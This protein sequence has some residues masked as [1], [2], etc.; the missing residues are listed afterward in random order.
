M[1]NSYMKLVRIPKDDEINT[2]L[3]PL[4]HSTMMHLFGKPGKLTKNCSPLTNPKLIAQ[5]VTRKFNNFTVTGWEP[6]VEDLHAILLDVYHFDKELHALIGSAGM[7]CCRMVR[8]ADGSPST[9]YSNHSWYCAFDMTFGGILVPQNA[10]MI[11][12]GMLDVYSIMHKHKWYW[13]AEFSTADP[14][15]SEPSLERLLELWAK[16]NGDTHWGV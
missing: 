6:A 14:M 8:H 4:K 10:T 7:G 12:Q 13:G 15:H 1:S 5:V 11:P 16:T 2:G 3:S 9:H